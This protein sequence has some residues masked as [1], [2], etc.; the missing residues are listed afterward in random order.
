[1]IEINLRDYYPF[2]TSDCLIDISGEVATLLPA[3]VRYKVA[4]QRVY[5]GTRLTR[6]QEWWVHDEA[7]I[8]AFSSDLHESPQ[9][10]GGSREAVSL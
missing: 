10:K 9:G 2:Y 4:F 8:H 1:M 5:T 7:I 6:R 3:H